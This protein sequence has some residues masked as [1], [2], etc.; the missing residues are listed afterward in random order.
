MKIAKLTSSDG[1]VY[2]L[3]AHACQLSTLLRAAMDEKEE[4]DEEEDFF[5]QGGLGIS[6]INRQSV[7]CVDIPLPA[8][9]GEVLSSVVR[10]MEVNS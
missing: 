3:S 2:E 1:Q 5:L 10:F 9:E 6:P 8:I 4:D 7:T